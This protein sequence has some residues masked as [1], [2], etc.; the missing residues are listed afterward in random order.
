MY[1]HTE[2]ALDCILQLCRLPSFLMDLYLNFTCN[3]YCDDLFGR[4]LQYL[5]Q[6]AHPEERLLSTNLIALESLLVSIHQLQ[7]SNSGA[8]GVRFFFP[9]FFFFFG[10]ACRQN[11]L[12]TVHV[13][14]HPLLLSSCSPPSLSMTRRQPWAR[15]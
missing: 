5:S 6:H 13:Y 3:L 2:A 10:R 1:E 11:V 12:A 14:L 15:P 8:S 7:R 4:V 9:F